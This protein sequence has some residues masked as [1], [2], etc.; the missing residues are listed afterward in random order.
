MPFILEAK[1]PAEWHVDNSS[2]P[3][4]LRDRFSAQVVSSRQPARERVLNLGTMA[5]VTPRQLIVTVALLP[6]LQFDGQ[7][8]GH[9]H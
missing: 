6:A 9:A 8:S 1:T 5:P 2:V 3:R 7:A 4:T